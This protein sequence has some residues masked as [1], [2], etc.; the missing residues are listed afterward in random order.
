MADIQCK[1]KT[2]EYTLNTFDDVMKTASWIRDALRSVFQDYEELD[3]HCYITFDSGNLSYDC[4]S[5]D[6]F[7]KYAFGKEINIKT[8]SIGVSRNWA[9]S[10]ISVYAHKQGIATEQEYV[11]SSADERLLVD[12]RDA[13]HTKKHGKPLSPAHMIINCEKH[14]DNSIHIGNNNQISNSMVGSKNKVEI[15]SKADE[16]ENIKESFASKTFWQFLVPIAVGV[17][18]V[19]VCAWLGLQ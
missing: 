8:I 5:I 16:S 18:V 6:E 4:K 7:K 15:E 3:S 14:E 13:L 1:Y 19:A 2:S 10:L 17:I 9:P 12:L 11:I